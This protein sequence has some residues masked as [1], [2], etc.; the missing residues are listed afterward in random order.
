LIEYRALLRECKILLIAYRAPLTEH[1][2]LLKGYRALWKSLPLTPRK[3]RTKEADVVLVRTSDS[4][5]APLSIFCICNV[6]Y[7]KEKEMGSACKKKRVRGI[8]GKK[9]ARERGCLHP[10]ARARAHTHTHTHILTYAFTHIYTHAHAHAP[11]HTH[12]NIRAS[13]EQAQPKREKEK[14][15]ACSSE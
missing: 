3:G 8:R 13:K 12:T 4:A 1:R 11:A 5:P 10:C 14:E 2:V 15:S 9:N 7:A 6:K